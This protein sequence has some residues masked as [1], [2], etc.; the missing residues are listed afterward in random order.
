MHHYLLCQVPLWW[1]NQFGLQLYGD[2]CY[3]LVVYMFAKR[4]Y[5][6]SKV[7]LISSCYMYHWKMIILPVWQSVYNVLSSLFCAYVCFVHTFVLANNNHY[8]T[9][10]ACFFFLS[11]SAMHPCTH[12]WGWHCFVKKF[13]LRLFL[14]VT[15]W[16]FFQIIQSL[17][18]W[19]RCCQGKWSFQVACS[20][21]WVT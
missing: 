16:Q 19:L 10:C 2:S 11:F 8:S 4:V 5:E 1:N 15:V 3:F 14:V 20:S 13:F 18:I 12:S 7:A 17:S 21:F 9:F 6:H